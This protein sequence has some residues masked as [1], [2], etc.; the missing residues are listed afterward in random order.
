MRY[1]TLGKPES[2]ICVTCE[3]WE[4]PHMQNRGSLNRPEEFVLDG[5]GHTSALCI[6]QHCKR[7]GSDHCRKHQFRYDLMRYL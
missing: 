7:R 1:I 4:G 6:K 5:E 2:K 3:Y